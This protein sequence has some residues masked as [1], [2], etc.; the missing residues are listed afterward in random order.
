ML[1]YN[2]SKLTI[3]PSVHLI[4]AVVLMHVAATTEP[5]NLTVQ[6]AL[7]QFVQDLSEIWKQPITD[8]DGA[9]MVTTATGSLVGRPLT[10]D[11]ARF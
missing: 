11:Y 7:N 8:R 6:L 5:G 4:K 3:A 9:K 1:Q 2:F 10:Q